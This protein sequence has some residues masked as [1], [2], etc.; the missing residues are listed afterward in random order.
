MAIDL[1]LKSAI[2]RRSLAID[3]AIR[4]LPVGSAFDGIKARTLEFE[5]F[6]NESQVSATSAYVF[7]DDINEAPKEFR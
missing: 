1:D 2:A 7:G 4:T 5:A 3:W 6:L